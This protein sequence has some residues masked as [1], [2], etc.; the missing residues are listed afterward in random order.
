MLNHEVSNDGAVFASREPYDPGDAMSLIVLLGDVAAHANPGWGGKVVF[1]DSRG[2]QSYHCC[3]CA[4]PS[5]GYQLLV[6][7]S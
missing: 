5:Y 7:I 2:R 6:D 1:D 4:L 3:K